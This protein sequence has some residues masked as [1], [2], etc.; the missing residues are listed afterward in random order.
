ML[1]GGL[2]AAVPAAPFLVGLQKMT[3]FRYSPDLFVVTESE[4]LMDCA[5]LLPLSGPTAADPR[6]D[7]SGGTSS[8]A[9]E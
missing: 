9:L 2:V 3:R 6:A 1:E 5:P 7:R 4:A 8:V